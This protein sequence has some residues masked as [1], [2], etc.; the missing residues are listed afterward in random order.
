MMGGEKSIGKALLLV[1]FRGYLDSRTYQIQVVLLGE[2]LDFH[3]S[4]FMVGYES[5]TNRLTH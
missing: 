1:K 5:V 3:S 2:I 4:P